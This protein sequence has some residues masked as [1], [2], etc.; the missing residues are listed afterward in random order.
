MNRKAVNQ[1]FQTINEA[2][3]TYTETA[4]KS[5][6]PTN[7]TSVTVNKI[8]VVEAQTREVGNQNTWTVTQS[9]QLPYQFY[10]SANQTN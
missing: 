1:S 3:E 7:N 4:K 8:V 6:V 5:T 2:F 9:G 10:P